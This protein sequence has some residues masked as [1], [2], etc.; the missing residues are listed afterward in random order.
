MVLW[1]SNLWASGHAIEYERREGTLPS[2]FLSPGSRSAVVF[3]SGIG[4]VLIMVA[5]TSLVLIVISTLLSITY[6]VESTAAAVLSIGGMLL[7]SVSLGYLLAGFFVLTRRANVIANFLQT[8][9]YLLSDAV[10]PVSELPETLQFFARLFPLSYGMEA[11][12]ESLLSG[13]TVQDVG[14]S[15][16][17][18]AVSSATIIVIGALLL[19]RVEHDA[20]NGAELDFE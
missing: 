16:I 1:T 14:P 13:A 6:V 7:A 18:I 8:P 5:P 17:G 2:L 9:I 20:R 10:L 15:L 11:V 3:G 4:S 12:R 19:R